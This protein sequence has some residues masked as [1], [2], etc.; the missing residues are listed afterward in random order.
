MCD[1]ADELRQLVLRSSLRDRSAGGQAPP[2][3]V[4]SGGKGGVGVTSVAVNLAVSLARQGARPLL[5]DADFDQPDATGLCSLKMA[6]SIADVLNGRRTVHE[7]LQRGPAGIQVLPGVWAPQQRVSCPPVAQERMLTELSRLGTHVDMVVL[8]VGSSRGSTTQ[9]FWQAANL[10]LVVTTTEPA[11]IMDAYAAIK[12]LAGDVPDTTPIRLVAN[13][14][15]GKLAA[16]V[17]DRVR[18]ACH[19]F[20]K[21]SIATGPCIPAWRTAAHSNRPQV[22]ELPQAPATRMLEELAQLTLHTVAASRHGPFA[23]STAA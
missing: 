19:K 3:V 14:A 22:L 4:V 8:D 17:F 12:M 2:L 23:H 20:L 7:V 21:L 11:A 16:P 15:D 18:D 5:V 1:Q 10:V 9:R 13:R 6:D